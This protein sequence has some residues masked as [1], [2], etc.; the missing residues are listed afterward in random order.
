MAGVGT[1]YAARQLTSMTAL[2][3]YALILS[4]W[5]VGRLVWVSRVLQNFL[6]VE[7][8]GLGSLSTDVLYAAEHTHLGVQLALIVAIVAFASLCADTLRSLSTPKYSGRLLA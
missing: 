8:D 7:K 3:I 5:V 4:L 6:Q 2:K 1:I